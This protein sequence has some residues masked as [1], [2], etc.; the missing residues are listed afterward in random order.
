MTE[1]EKKKSLQCLFYFSLLNLGKK[2][3]K[4]K[5]SIP[6]MVRMK[7]KIQD[8]TVNRKRASIYLFLKN[9]KF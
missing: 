7:I 9:S 8:K 6:K 4:F 5:K 3:S 2:M 1:G